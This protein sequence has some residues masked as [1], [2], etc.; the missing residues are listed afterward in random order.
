MDKFISLPNDMKNIEIKDRLIYLVIKSHD[1]KKHECFPSLQCVSKESGIGIKAIRD[2]IKRLEEAGYLTVNKKD[3]KN[4]YLFNSCKK[5]EPF[6]EE[7]LKRKDLSPT[8][9]GYIAAIQQY[10]IKDIEGVG[11]IS[12]SNREL[13]KNINTSEFTVR[14]CNLEL[15]KNNFLTTIKNIQKDLETGCL[16]E[17]KLFKLEELGQAIIWK[18]K[19]HEDRLKYLE[20]TVESQGQFINKYLVQKEVKKTEFLI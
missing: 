14:K 6:S 13:A 15:V 20:D 3:G 16:T 12:Y 1:N 17:T 9:K 10:M 19:E 11:K 4:Y 5:F 7:F 2:S 18:L 8:T